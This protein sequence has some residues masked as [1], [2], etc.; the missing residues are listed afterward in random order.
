MGELELAGNRSIS[1]YL[2][3]LWELTI[4][5]S[6]KFGVILFI[7]LVSITSTIEDIKNAYKLL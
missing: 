7:N 3:N 5:W 6:R 2:N 4:E 1:Y